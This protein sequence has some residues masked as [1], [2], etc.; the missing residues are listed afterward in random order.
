MNFTLEVMRQSLAHLMY[1]RGLFRLQKKKKKKKKC[2]WEYSKTL[3]CEHNSFWKHACNPKHLYIR[4]ISRTIG[5]LVIMWCSAITELLIKHCLSTKLRFI[6]HVC[7]S[8]G[9]LAEKLLA[10]QS[11]TGIAFHKEEFLEKVFVLTS[12]LERTLLLKK[13]HNFYR[14][15][16]NS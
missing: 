11:F 15:Q 5:S 7:S 12:L 13:S 4:E 9:T 8:C 1:L 10:I 6:R 14:S 2:N 3:V 16:K